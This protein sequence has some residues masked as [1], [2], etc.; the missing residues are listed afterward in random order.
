[1]E[2]RLMP[3]Y[4]ESHFLSAAEVV[5]LRTEA[6][7]DGLWRVEHVLADLRSERLAAVRR[8][9]RPEAGYRKLTFY[10]NHL[11][12]DQHLDAVLLGPGHA[13]YA[14]VD[15]RLRESLR[16]VTAGTGVYVD[17]VAEVPY[18]LHF[19]DIAVRGQTTEGGAATIHAELV[20]VREA[21]GVGASDRYCFV[22]ADALIDLAA[23][24]QPPETVPDLDLEPVTDFVKST[25]QME[26]RQ[27]AQAQRGRYADVARDYLGRS[28]DARVRSAQSRV[29][30]LRARETKE[31]EVALARQRAE[32]ELEDLRRTRRERLAGIDRLRIARH[33]PVRH[34]ACCLVLPADAEAGAVPFPADEPDAGLRRRIELAAEDVAVAHE[35]SRGRTC[36]RVGHLKIGFDVRSLAPPDPQTGYLDPVNGVRRIEVKGR[37]RGQPVRLTTNE[38]YKAQQ[39]GDT[40]WLYVVWDPL[41]DPDPVPLMVRNPA[42]CLDHAKREIVAAR[43]YDL[44]A[45]AVEQAARDQRGE[46][47]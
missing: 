7:A 40:Y 41:D 23:H 37:R 33:G 11:E 38:W 12:Q 47:P 26:R 30:A 9:G 24:P 16:D 3:R 5:G 19:L 1:E 14:A 35:E 13:L 43:Y 20:G 25:I 2:R 18:R 4:V 21:L 29:M 28:F 45:D 8:L 10:K 31:P 32:Q 42:A 22:P 34:V 15:E 17:P 6:R 44:P 27:E 36:E 46:S 39:L